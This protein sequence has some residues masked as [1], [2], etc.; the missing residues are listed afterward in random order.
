VD[1][2]AH[3]F[4]EALKAADERVG[5]ARQALALYTGD[6]LPGDVYEDWPAPSRARLQRSFVSLT[7]LLAHD[8]ID[9]GELD[10]AARLLDLGLGVEPLDENRATLLCRVY[11]E[12]GRISAAAEVARRCA[13]ALTELGLE[14]GAGLRRY[15]LP[16]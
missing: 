3:P 15:L 5:R 11:A 12:Q 4:R 6:L 9:R 7:D 13:E 1:V 10:E 16:G 8:C 2:T 14:P